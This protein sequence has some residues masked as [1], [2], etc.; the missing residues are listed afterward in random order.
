MTP[1]IR[2]RLFQIGF[3]VILQGVL[4]FASAGTMQW[5]SAWVFLAL[6]VAFVAVNGLIFFPAKT[7]G[8]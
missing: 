4:L 6:Y 8:R 2:K 3:L 1:A 7:A 5:A